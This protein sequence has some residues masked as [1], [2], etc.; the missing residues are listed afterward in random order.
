MNVSNHI[1]FL[2]TLVFFMVSCRKDK[3]SIPVEIPVTCE[4]AFNDTSY[5]EI[6]IGVPSYNVTILSPA[7]ALASSPTIDSG[8]VAL[9]SY[10]D[11]GVWFYVYNSHSTASGGFDKFW[12]KSN[13]SNIQ[14]AR[15]D[16]LWD[17][18]HYTKY[19]TTYGLSEANG[20]EDSVWEYS[21][22]YNSTSY[23]LAYGY[24]SITQIEQPFPKTFEVGE[25][26]TVSENWIEEPLLYYDLKA[27]GIATYEILDNVGDSIYWTYHSSKK[28]KFLGFPF[29]SDQF[30]GFKYDYEG[31]T[32]LGWLKLYVKTSGILI[33][34][35]GLH[36]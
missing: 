19:D 18:Y 8:F 4:T 3:T 17:I 29:G 36:N 30:I 24:D 14:F 31:H 11:L 32:K 16:Y 9:S 1:L 23:E 25:T 6:E 2:L 5:S 12:F 28:H 33:L 20:W 35:V 21:S 27:G 13:I 10:C 22:K 15:G 7:F 34:E 26:M